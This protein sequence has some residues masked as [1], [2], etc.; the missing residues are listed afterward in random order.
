MSE[1]IDVKD[2]LPDLDQDVLVFE[3]G[4]CENGDGFFYIAWFNGI[5]WCSNLVNPEPSHW[6]PINR[7]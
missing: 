5:Y 7:P 6:M 2:E 3:P 1:W 4:L